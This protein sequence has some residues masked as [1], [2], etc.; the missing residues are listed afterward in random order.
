MTMQASGG[1][2]LSGYYLGGNKI[3]IEHEHEHEN[4]IDTTDTT[5]TT[6]VE[7]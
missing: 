6:P 4:V 3:D 2:I 7:K 1:F 5:G